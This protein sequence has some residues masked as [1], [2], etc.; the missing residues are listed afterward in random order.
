MKIGVFLLKVPLHKR[1]ISYKEKSSHLVLQTVA[2]GTLVKWSRRT[3]PVTGE[4]EMMPPPIKC[5]EETSESHWDVLNKDAKPESNH[6]EVT[7]YSPLRDTAQGTCLSSE[8]SRSWTSRKCEEQFKV[9]ENEETTMW[10]WTG[11][12]GHKGH[13]VQF[14]HSVVSESLW[15]HGLQHARLPCPSPT[16]R[17]YSNSCPLSWWCHPTISSSVVPFSFCLQSFPVSGSFPMSQ[18]FTLGGQSAEASASASM[19]MQHWFPLG[20]TLEQLARR[21]VRGS[22]IILYWH[23]FPDLE[24]VLWLC[25]MPLF[26]GNAP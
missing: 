21:G 10:F 19:K 3:S 23:Q 14:S 5:S 15:P 8:V 11:S 12:T 6:K 17:A 9:K 13:S 25:R 2:E 4:I 22:M 24:V 16:P 1:L 26:V 18:L 20:L 7:D